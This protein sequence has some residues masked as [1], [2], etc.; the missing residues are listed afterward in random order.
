MELY[1]GPFEI[2]KQTVKRSVEGLVAADQNIVVTGFCVRSH[3]LSRRGPQA[4]F[5]PIADNR[6]SDFFGDRKADPNAIFSF[7]S[8][9]GPRRHLDHDTRRRPAPASCDPKKVSS[10]L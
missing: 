5:R 2:V 8:L 6:I 3:H 10:F 9:T 4:A 7:R 1:K